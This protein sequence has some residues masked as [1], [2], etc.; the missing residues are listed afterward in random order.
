MPEVRRTPE[1]E[2][3]RPSFVAGRTKPLGKPVE[4]L[5]NRTLP[6]LT[7]PELALDKLQ[8]HTLLGMA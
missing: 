6:E 5:A 8:H 2:L 7:P 1:E 3:P 4:V